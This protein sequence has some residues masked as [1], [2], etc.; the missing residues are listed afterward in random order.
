[1]TLAEL[2]KFYDEENCKLQ[3]KGNGS[4]IVFSDIEGYTATDIIRAI[5]EA[6]EKK[7]ITV[8]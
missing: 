7:R 3:I 5:S 4:E 6:A 8:I 2:S 1:M